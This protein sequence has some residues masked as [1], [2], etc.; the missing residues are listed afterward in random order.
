[1]PFIL[2]DKAKDHEV[3][4]QWVNELI[5]LGEG[6]DLEGY[7]LF[8]SF[9]GDMSATQIARE[10]F[11]FFSVRLIFGNGCHSNLPFQNFKE[12]ILA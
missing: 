12:K 8:A 11:C 10:P 5:Q 9:L 1:M 4:F 2:T 3:L 6:D 7:A